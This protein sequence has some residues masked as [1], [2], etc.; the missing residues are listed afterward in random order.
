[1]AARTSGAT[2]LHVHD[3]GRSEAE[4]PL[5]QGLDA[6]LRLQR[7]RAAPGQDLAGEPV[8]DR[9]QVEG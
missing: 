2:M 9:D 5:V 8:H 1:M 7:V 4:A 6:E 3:L